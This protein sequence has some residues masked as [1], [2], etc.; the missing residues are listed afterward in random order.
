MR[1]MDL[2]LVWCVIAGAAFSGCGGVK[3]R[4]PWE[5]ETAAAPVVVEATAPVRIDHYLLVALAGEGLRALSLSG[6]AGNALA[7]A[8]LMTPIDAAMRPFMR[9]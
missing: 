4:T 3:L 6:A 7:G 2:P 8:T 9:K 5:K 1:R